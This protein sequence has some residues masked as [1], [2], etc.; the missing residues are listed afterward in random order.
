MTNCRYAP[1]NWNRRD[2][3]NRQ[4]LWNPDW[5]MDNVSPGGGRRDCFFP[6]SH[7]Y[8]LYRAFSRPGY[9]FVRP[10]SFSFHPNHYPFGPCLGSSRTFL[11]RPS[12]KPVDLLTNGWYGGR[13]QPDIG[14]NRWGTWG[15]NAHSPRLNWPWT[16]NWLVVA[17]GVCVRARVCVCVCVCVC[18]SLFSLTM[19]WIS[20]SSSVCLG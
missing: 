14:A 16:I 12:P 20:V 1:W 6:H 13:G 18:V 7:P 5:S 19:S 11:F 2:W 4:D 3:W 15:Q 9:N 17:V 8:R 10:S